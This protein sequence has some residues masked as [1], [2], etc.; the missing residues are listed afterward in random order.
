MG[1]FEDHFARGEI[2]IV[3]FHGQLD[4]VPGDSSFEGK[5][6]DAERGDERYLVLVHL[7]VADIGSLAGNSDFS[8]EVGSLLLEDEGE[9][10]VDAIR[11]SSLDFTGSCAGDV[12]SKRG[13]RA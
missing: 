7:S 13:E 10:E 3:G 12:R 11:R 1:A 6:R 5:G 8:G 2:G 9:S 4:L